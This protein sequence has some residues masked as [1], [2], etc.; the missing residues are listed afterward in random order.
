MLTSILPVSIICG[1][2]VKSPIYTLTA[3]ASVI[4]VLPFSISAIF[5][6]VASVLKSPIY[7]LTVIA[8]VL[9]VLSF[10]CFLSF[11]PKYLETQF[12]VPA[13]QSNLIIGNIFFKLIIKIQRAIQG[14]ISYGRVGAIN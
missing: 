3:V 10:S 8:S 2:A 9:Q 14:F 1:T 13:W 11:E 12:S 5:G 4:Q 6:T 7:T